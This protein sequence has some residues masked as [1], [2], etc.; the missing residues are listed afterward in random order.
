MNA[1]QQHDLLLS[2]RYKNTR[3][4]LWLEGACRHART[5]PYP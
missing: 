3:F 5:N 1:A 4:L 2:M